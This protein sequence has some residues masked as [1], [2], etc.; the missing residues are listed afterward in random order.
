M[1]LPQDVKSVINHMKYTKT[2]CTIGPA[3]ETPEM[4]E[5]MARAGMNIARLNFSHGSH[6]EH[7]ARIA[8]LRV[9]AEKTG[10]TISILQDLQGPKIRMGILEQPAM[11]EKGQQVTLGEGGYPTQY[12]LSDLVK[13]GQRVLID[14]GLVEIKVD[15][16]KPKAI[17][18]T[19]ITGGKG[20]HQKG[21]QH[22]GEQHQVLGVH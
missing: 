19:V 10:K 9:I 14:D 3:S 4:L 13:V 21:D 16:I 15:K 6:D 11:F 17:I 2:V 12:N 22:P 8:T 20:L 5:A 1:A 18:C 7:A